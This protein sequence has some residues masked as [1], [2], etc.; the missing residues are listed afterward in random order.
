LFAL[1]DFVNAPD[2]GKISIVKGYHGTGK[3]SIFYD[4]TL[5]RLV[6]KLQTYGKNI[7]ASSSGFEI[8]Q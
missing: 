6:K 4:V 2:S 5:F 8:Y 3:E 7:K 1:R